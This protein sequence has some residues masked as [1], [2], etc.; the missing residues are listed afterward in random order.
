MQ[1]FVRTK[2]REG[3]E[4]GSVLLV[5]KKW[6]AS[7]SRTSS[8]ASTSEKKLKIE[9]ASHQRNRPRQSYSKLKN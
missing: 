3:M 2:Q 7:P 9:R 1:L 6:K 8:R 4:G 5:S